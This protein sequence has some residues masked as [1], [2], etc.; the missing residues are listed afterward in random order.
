MNICTCICRQWTRKDRRKEPRTGER[1]PYVIVYGAPGLPL[2]QLVRSPKNVLLD[3][4]LRINSIYY[5]TRAII[6]PLERCF[7]LLGVDVNL[8]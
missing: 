7:S 3:P 8:W 5:I 4:A 2:I 1:V 6:P